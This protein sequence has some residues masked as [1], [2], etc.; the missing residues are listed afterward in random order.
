MTSRYKSDNL[1]KTNKEQPEIN[2]QLQ[3]IKECKQKHPFQQLVE[4]DNY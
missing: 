1:T 3:N 4:A 2:V